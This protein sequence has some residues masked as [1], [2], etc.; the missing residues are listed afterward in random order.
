MNP[1]HGVNF[2]VYFGFEIAKQS[3]EQHLGLDIATFLSNYHIAQPI[4][5]TSQQPSTTTIESHE[6]TLLQFDRK[7]KT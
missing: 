5:L 4:L 3:I 6:S 2:Y 7:L 1:F